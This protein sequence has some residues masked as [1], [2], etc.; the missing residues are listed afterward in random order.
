MKSMARNIAV[1][2]VAL[3]AGVGRL[4]AQEQLPVKENAD[5]V[6]RPAEFNTPQADFSPALLRG[7]QLMV[8]TSARSGGK[9]ERIWIA[10]RTSSGWSTPKP[11]GEALDRAK[12]IGGATLTPD[13]NFMI[14]AAYEWDSHD[15]ALRGEG[16]TDLYSAER[17]DGE[18]K[19][20]R[21]LGPVI[22]SSYWDSQPSLS[23][24]GRT[25]Y[26]ASNRPGGRGGSDIYVS[27]LGWN[28][29]SEPVNLDGPINTP[30]DDMTPSVAPDDATLFFSSN[31]HGGAGGF[32]IFVATGNED[33]GESWGDVENIGTPVNSASDD[34]CFI[35][36]P[37]TR[38]GFFSSNRSGNFEIYMAD[39][40][41][42]PAG[43]LVTIAGKVLDARTKVP[44]AASITVTDLGTNEVMG[45]FKT[46]D[47]TGEYYVVLKRGWRYSITAEAPGYIFYSDEYSVPLPTSSRDLKKDVLLQKTDGGTT[48]LLV[49]FDY[50]KADLYEESYSDLDRAVA[51]LRKNPSAIVEIIG[52][53]DSVGS[54]TYNHSLSR[55]RAEAV[56]EY[57]ADQGINLSRITA[58]GHG[59]EHPV[60]DNG[61]EEGRARNRRVEM[62]V[63]EPKMVGRKP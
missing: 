13:G 36:L 11:A 56:R 58:R 29:W 44:V 41:P 7:G 63:T 15:P 26:F 5:V 3:V 27:H 61:T 8:F 37:N 19:N 25:L 34:H 33:N 40:N 6:V 30:K 47:R 14:F 23:S 24:D 46:D 48:R 51:F 9:G 52:H 38:H 59:E 2:C 54:A 10:E 62:K 28:G 50:D 49:F 32:D 21:H 45:D 4:G 60:A 39:P 57:L 20:V 43:A 12:H 35:S 42:R 16:R 18:W 31:G 55:N 1:S 53:T 17:F 22:N